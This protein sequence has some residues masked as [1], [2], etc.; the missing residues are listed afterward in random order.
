MFLSLDQPRVFAVCLII[1]IISGAF[2]E[3]FGF[4]ICF[5][6][7]RLIKHAIKFVWV[8]LCLPI[9]ITISYLYEFPDFRGYMALGVALG[10][11]L[12][13]LS[14]HKVFAI[15]QNKVYNIITKL[16]KIKGQGMNEAKK[17]RIFS[18]V[19]SGLIMLTV[20]LV[21]IICYQLVGIFTRKNKIAE[22]DSEIEY[23]KSQ[24]ELTEDEIASWELEWKIIERAR[25]LGMYFEQDEDAV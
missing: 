9:F 10:I 16:V 13:K 14:F 5:I 15:L 1:G 20:I 17:R 23:L 24:I 25:E 22:L 7:Q 8:I 19:L 2:Y 3:V 11:Y 18:A 12:Y 6:K 4:I 21:S